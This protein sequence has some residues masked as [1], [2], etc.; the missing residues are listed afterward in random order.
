MIKTLKMLNSLN[1]NYLTT[2]DIAKFLSISRVTVY[3]WIKSGK[4]KAFRVPGG[5]YKIFKK[6]FLNFLKKC[7]GTTVEDEYKKTE[8][9]KILV[10]DDEPKIVE[11]IKSFLEEANPNFH[12]IGA[13]S[14]F[15][16][17]RLVVSFHPHIVIL[18]I[19]M[20]GMDGL[21]V[22]RKIKSDPATED[23]EIIA[24]TG[25]PQ[26]A[27]MI[28]KEGASACLIKPFSYETLLT[29]IKRILKQKK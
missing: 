2:G 20:P 27:E 5:K 18:D 16:A 9:V 8:V 10:V 29:E 28:K 22:C 17:G 14:G 1:K 25:Y 26:K 6:E 23:I 13:T 12:V 21:A 11:T 4:L 19:V 15:E 7:C 3:N 24:I